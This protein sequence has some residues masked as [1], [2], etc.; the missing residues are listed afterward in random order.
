[1]TIPGHRIPEWFWLGDISK[2]IPFQPPART[3]STIPGCSKLTS[4]TSRD[5]GA[6]TAALGSFC[7]RVPPGICSAAAGTNCSRDHDCVVLLVNQLSRGAE[8][9]FPFFSSRGK[10]EGPQHTF[11]PSIPH[12][13]DSRRELAAVGGT[14]GRRWVFSRSCFGGYRSDCSPGQAEFPLPRQEAASGLTLGPNEGSTSTPTAGES[15]AGAATTLILIPS[16]PGAFHSHCHEQ[17]LPS[18]LEESPAGK[19]YS[20]SPKPAVLV[21]EPLNLLS[22]PCC[23]L[24]IPP[25][26]VYTHPEQRKAV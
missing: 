16:R 18:L 3:P 5:A 20:P 21:S 24:D 6:A 9:S 23:R 1:M 13:W 17:R 8:L 10:P 12:C 25:C 19:N 11:L 2:P 7:Q 26:L 14:R 15:G 22:H 4:D